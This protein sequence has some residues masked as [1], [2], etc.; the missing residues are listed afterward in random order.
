MNFFDRLRFRF[1]K[2]LSS[3][4]SARKVALSISLGLVLGIIPFFL[5]LNILLA[6]IVSWRLR[7]NHLLIQFVSNVIYPIQI[8]LFLPFLRAGVIP[9]LVIPW[10]FQVF[11]YFLFFVTMC[12]V[13]LSF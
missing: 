3:E 6:A 1:L 9:F 11:S 7:L 13:E 8:L 2:L 10:S 12:L 4:L 5:G